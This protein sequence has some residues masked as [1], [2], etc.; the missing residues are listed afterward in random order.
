MRYGA[1]YHLIDIKSQFIESIDNV[2]SN[3]QYDD[4]KIVVNDPDSSNQTIS[5]LRKCKIGWLE[6]EGIQNHMFDIINEVNHVVG[7]NF[8]LKG[9]EPPQYTVY[10]SG[11]YYDWHIDQNPYT[12]MSNGVVKRIRKL[13]ASIF[14]NEPDEYDGGELELELAGPSHNSRN[15]SFKL[16]KGSAI[17]FQSDTWHRVLP[18]K[19]GVR[20]SLVVWSGGPPYI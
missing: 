5:N 16:T 6:D 12:T 18:V 20:K 11:N 14:L 2:I 9:I 8:D 13:S 1:S 7:W 3:C 19:S 10:E 17:I 4:A 15:K